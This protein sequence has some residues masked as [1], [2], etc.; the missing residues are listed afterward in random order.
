MELPTAR[1][2]DCN[3]RVLVYQGVAPCADP[4][5]A[6]LHRYC[7]DCD[8]RLDRFGSQPN[9][10]EEPLAK[11]VLE[12]YRDLDSGAQALE[13]GCRTNKGCDDCPKLSTRP[14]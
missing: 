14:F 3:R 12:G 5:T 11:L 7:A 1:C 13:P 10:A 4:M 6:P 8:T 9:L 2:P